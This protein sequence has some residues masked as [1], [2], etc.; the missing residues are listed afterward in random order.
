MHWIPIFRH[1]PGL[2]AGFTTKHGGVSQAPYATRNLGFFAGDAEATVAEN[3]RTLLADL[4]LGDHGLVLPRLVHGA[5]W[6]WIE[7]DASVGN[8]A[9]PRETR[10]GLV[11]LAPPE[12]DAVATMANDLVL[13]VTM[14]DCMGMLIYDSATGCM[15]AVHAGW[16]GTRAGILQHTLRGLFAAGHAKPQ[17]TWVGL[18]PALGTGRLGLS[19]E[20]LATMDA[21]FVQDIDMGRGLDMRAWNRQQAL[22]AG[23]APERIESVDLCT[24]DTPEHLF[25]YRREGP[26]SGRMAALIA[27]L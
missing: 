17:T 16:R 6:A 26:Q 20:I 21:R 18:G 22:E 27:R 24:Y 9:W 25:S 7:N 19:E 23:L 1:I 8:N 4:G 12:A 15:A 2:V 10:A 5:N 13:A 14:A 11:L 3:W